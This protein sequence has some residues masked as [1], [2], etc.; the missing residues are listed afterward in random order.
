[1]SDYKPVTVDAARQ[2]AEH[3]EKSIVIISTWDEKHG[4]LHVTTY[5]VGARRKLNAATGGEIVEKAL[6]G[7]EGLELQ[8]VYEDFRRDFDAAALKESL[9]ILSQLKGGPIELQARIRKLFE[10]RAVAAAKQQ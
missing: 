10:E 3:F 5:G 4:L 2:L 1:M 6:G 9:D 7:A 8:K